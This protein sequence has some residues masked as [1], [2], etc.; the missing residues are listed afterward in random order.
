MIPSRSSSATDDEP[1]YFP[2]SSTHF[3]LMDWLA[4]NADEI[5]TPSR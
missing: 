1:N 4:R 3:P 5:L 2:R